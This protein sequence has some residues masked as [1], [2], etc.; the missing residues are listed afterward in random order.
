MGIT[1]FFKELSRTTA[2]HEEIAVW[3]LYVDKLLIPVLDNL[4]LYSNYTYHPRKEQD[5]H[6][7]PMLIITKTHNMSRTGQSDGTEQY[8]SSLKAKM[9]PKGISLN[10]SK[11]LPRLQG[12]DEESVRKF[13]EDMKYK[14]ACNF[15]DSCS[16]HFP[17]A[18]SL[19]GTGTFEREKAE[20]RG[21]KAIAQ[22][23]ENFIALITQQ[24]QDNRQKLVV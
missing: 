20:Q 1:T 3:E 16:A 6:G 24:T 21:T 2:T 13:L 4:S 8:V 7:N 11:E 19:I 12:L 23:G 15:S 22:I 9:G 10:A 14:Y 5:K 17:E 18:A